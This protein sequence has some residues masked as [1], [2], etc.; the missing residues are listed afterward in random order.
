MLNDETIDIL[1]DKLRIIQKKNGFKFGIDAV[2][3]ADFMRL[4][5][6]ERLCDICTGS[7]IVAILASRKGP[8]QITAVEIQ[9]DYADMAG[10][11]V[12]MNEI[13][14]LITVL[15]GDIREIENLLAKHSFEV[16]SANPP[17]KELQGGISAERSDR[18]I[19]KNEVMVNLQEVIRCA[20][21]L[22]RPNGRFYMVH[23]TERLAD[24]MCT[25]REYKLE[26]KRMRMVQ[27]TADKPPSLV[28]IEAQKGAKPKLIA[29]PTLIVMEN[30]EE[31]PE[32]QRIYGRT[33]N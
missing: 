22:L 6:N 31:T 26:V 27:G 23:R 32:I 21:Y 3:L 25:L 16:V 30:G 1:D 29:M 14:N 12:K 10:R 24:I 4:Y 17:Y 19:A 15:N 9:E 33:H 28:L 20:E 7:G 2:L 11:S 13:H 18:D 8:K 5:K